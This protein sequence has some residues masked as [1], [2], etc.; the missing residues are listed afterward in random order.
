M[1]S[2]NKMKRIFFLI[3]FSTANCWARTILLQAPLSSNAQYEDFLNNHQ[4]VQ[5]FVDHLTGSLQKNYSQESQLFKLTDMFT[6]NISNTIQALKVIQSESALTLL[7]LRYIRDLS[8]KSLALGISVRERQEF[9][10]I[11]CKSALLLKE[12]PILYSCASQHIALSPLKKRY[13][14]IVKVLIETVPFAVEDKGAISIIE[15]TPYQ[16]T[17]LSNAF[18]PIHFF[19]TFQQ[20]M[21]QQFQFEHLINGDCESFSHQDLD[22]EVMNEGV[23]FFSETC[24]KK[25]KPFDDKK[26][27]VSENKTLL[28]VAGGLVVTGLIYNYTKGKKYVIDTTSFK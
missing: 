15:Q 11:Y 28:L 20:L 9:Q 23:V 27:W 14:Q 18:A 6:Q 16:W 21:N 26:S 25:V 2:L 10:R 3:I 5:S 7:S 24:Q 1:R 8:E 13:P 19:G 4:D 22:L 12:G 17:L